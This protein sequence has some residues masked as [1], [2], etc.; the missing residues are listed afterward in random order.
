MA[1]QQ[2]IREP[3]RKYFTILPNLYDDADLDVYEFRL[4]AHYTRVGNCW[5]STRTTAKKCHMSL[6]AVV[7]K[8]HSLASKGWIDLT[9]SEHGTVRI[10]LIDKW[11]ENTTIYRGIEDAR[12]PGEQKRSWSERARSPG[13]T[14]EEL[15][16]KNKEEE[17]PAFLGFADSA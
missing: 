8:R 16:K 13:D 1:E 12:S 7:K 4:L 10:V 17:T 5:E 14:K 9:E 3:R 15:I 6:G 2:Q 11:H